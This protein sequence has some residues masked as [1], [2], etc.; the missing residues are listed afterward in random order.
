[1]EHNY[2]GAFQKECNPDHPVQDLANSREVV[3]VRL[4]QN[5]RWNHEHRQQQNPRCER[6]LNTC[7]A[8]HLGFWFDGAAGQCPGGQSAA[9]TEVR[10]PPSVSS[11]SRALIRIQV[12]IGVSRSVYCDASDARISIIRSRKSCTESVSNA[13]MNS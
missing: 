2:C 11:A 8:I 13:V 6:V 12:K 10:T 3:S 5:E 4:L 9:G 1:T 7:C